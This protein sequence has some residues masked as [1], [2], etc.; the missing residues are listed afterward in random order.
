MPFFR[1]YL[2]VMMTQTL[3]R[4]AQ[5]IETRLKRKPFCFPDHKPP[6]A[7]TLYNVFQKFYAGKVQP[8]MA[9]IQRQGNPWFTLH[10]ELI[11]Q[12]PTS[13]DMQNYQQQVLGLDIQTSLWG[14]WVQ[15]RERHTKAWQ[16]ILGQC[17]MM[18]GS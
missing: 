8:Y 14:Q 6:R 16:A 10:D 12:L 18:P 2:V 1:A 4:T 13:K 7:T 9:V 3:D 5:A 17:N 15:A 11:T